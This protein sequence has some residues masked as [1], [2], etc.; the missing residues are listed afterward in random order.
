MTNRNRNP[1]AHKALPAQPFCTELRH[2]LFD[3]TIH[4]NR[5][6]CLEALDRAAC[7]IELLEHLDPDQQTQGQL[8]PRA[9][10]G[11]RHLAQMLYETFAYSSHRLAV[12]SRKWQRKHRCKVRR[13]V[14]NLAALPQSLAPLN[15]V[16]RDHSLNAMTSRLQLTRS[17]IDTLIANAG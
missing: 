9:T 15:T 8:T 12:L 14:R 3:T 6:D 10:S 16:D 2:P 5:L 17:D 4:P 7:V 1:F 13:K 11:Y